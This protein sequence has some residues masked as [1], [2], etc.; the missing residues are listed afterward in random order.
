M[1]K[2]SIIIPT[3]NREKELR[4]CIQSILAQTM[5]P[6]ELIVIDDGKL[7]EAPFKNECE[8]LGIEYT[9]T[10]KGMPG[11]AESRNVGTRLAR[12]DIIFFFD[13]DVVL[14]PSYIEKILKTY[15]NDQKE[16][17]GGVGGIITNTK[18][19]TL[20][21]RIRRIYNIFFLLSGLKEGKVPP[22]GFGTNYGTTGFQIKKVMEVDFL[23]GCT[24]SF[25]K[26][27]FQE[28]SFNEK[29]Y[30]DY[31]LGEDQD[32]AY[33]VSRKHKLIINPEAQLLH[34]ESSKMKPNK[35][36]M[37]QKYIFF[38]YL[39]FKHHIKKAWWSWIFFYYALFGYI[40]A[41]TLILLLSFD[42]TEIARLRGILCTVKDIIRGRI[43]I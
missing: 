11:L 24:M 8:D 9:Y 15:Q 7:L 28:F 20:T 16:I 29:R 36:I 41:R 1:L 31:G 3:Y 34:L 26:K 33:Q 25:R 4:C 38:K 2:G 22:S 43:S 18:P 42:K 37:G 12:G 27:I 10:R 21:L 40:L 39:F 14:S 5:K 6:F 30:L 35:K 32:F 17:I 23:P 13:D 19:L